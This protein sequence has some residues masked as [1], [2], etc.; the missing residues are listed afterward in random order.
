MHKK[1]FIVLVLLALLLA[2]VLAV[3]AQPAQLSDH[4]RSARPIQ[5]GENQAT[6]TF[7]DLGYNQA[8]LVSPY[9]STRV[10][11]SIPPNWKL[12][13]GGEVELTYDVVLSGADVS[14]ITDARNPYGGT[15]TI[16]FNNQIIG[17]APLD[18]LG[19]QTVRF[20]I[21]QE[22]LASIRDDGR[23]QLVIS[24]SAAFS[25]IYDIRAIVSIKNTSLFNLLFEASSPQ[26]DLSKLPAPFYLRNS[27][28][29]DSTLLVTPDSPTEMEMQAAL[30]VMSGLGSIIGEAY[31]VS[32]VPAGQ[33]TDQ[34]LSANNLILVGK[35][36]QLGL[37][38]NIQFP[39][40]VSNGKF[41]N[42]P[43]ESAQDG[44]L[45]M[46]L[47]PWNA[48]KIALLVSGADDAAVV[49]A[50]QAVSSGKIFVYENPALAYISDVQTLAQT[51]P[52]VED[53]S[54][55]SL[56]YATETLN[57]VG[58]NNVQYQF[59]AS[60]EQVSGQDGSIDLVYYHSA[61]LNYGVSSLTIS[62]ND[63]VIGSAV[64]SKDSEQLTTLNL[65]VPSG[66]LRFGENR[67]A[68]STSLLLE[69]SC[70]TTGFSN[71]WLVISDQTSFHLPAGTPDAVASQKL[72]DLR[73]Y[74]NLFMTRSDLGDVAFVLP[75]A[76][77]ASWR[78]AGQ[79]AYDL[80]RSANSLISNVRAVYADNV[81]AD[82]QDQ[83]SMILVGK[84]S[85]LPVL[86]SINEN[87]PAPFDLASNTASEKDMQ[88]V[89]RIPAGVSVG[90]VELIHSPYNLERK[91]LIAS[92]NDDA[93]LAL[94]GTML[95]Q[96]PLKGQLTGQ[97][98]VTNGT[99]V[100]TGSPSA[101]FSAVS[102]VVPNAQQ[103]IATPITPSNVSQ[104]GFSRPSWLNWLPAA[105]GLVVLVIILYV[106][107]VALARG[108]EPAAAR[109]QR[110]EKSGKS[111]N[112]GDEQKH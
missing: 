31:N 70:D 64:F 57:G 56:G 83:Y 74:P 67:L 66:L 3:A 85:D 78:V 108:R 76:N 46:A 19:T 23:H 50:A 84:A 5:I 106:V 61:L 71:P 6:V 13:P 26:L 22:A 1:V 77:A 25:C 11:F 62:L 86:A 29:P 55:E 101:Q 81:P 109:A 33:L 98:A 39:V 79:L 72:L 24:L 58:L 105:S 44:I 75:K 9:D 21:P 35:P 94:A 47:S 52:S 28:V 97:F 90:Y 12:V 34:D 60:K 63:Q 14:K 93:G 100:A 103:V 17:T 54:L 91:I 96:N 42:L 59:Y 10:L 68:V 88:I 49:K 8:D 43:A 16:T 37:L 27:L 92:G 87:L 38:S 80:G 36:E 102:T 32:L 30:N 2:N 110:G 18:Q 4:P 41:T 107:A 69:T 40:P 89:Y 15:L 20:E 51:I 111:S 112:G 73:F 65:K 99:Q 48:N 45:E 7:A 95:T 104:P 82:L 53:F